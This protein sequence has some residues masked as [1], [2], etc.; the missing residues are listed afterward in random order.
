[1]LDEDPRCSE[2][3]PMFRNVDHPGIGTVLTAT[4]PL[5]FGASAR[6]AP[7][8]APRL[9]EHTQA[10]LADVLGLDPGTIDGLRA[11]GTIGG[12]ATGAR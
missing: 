10:V 8:V 7:G 4:T 3:N 9:G 6:V 1:M 2:A 5:A 11:A 12:P